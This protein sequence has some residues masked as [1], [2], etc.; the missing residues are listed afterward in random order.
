MFSGNRKTRCWTSIHIAWPAVQGRILGVPGGLKF[1]ETGPKPCPN[2]GV[3]LRWTG[4]GTAINNYLEI[5]FCF[6]FFC[7]SLSRSL[8]LSILDLIS[9]HCVYI[10]QS[11]L[12]WLDI[13]IYIYCILYLMIFNV[14]ILLYINYIHESYRT[15]NTKVIHK[16]A[17]SIYIYVHVCN[18]YDM[19]KLISPKRKPR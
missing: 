6:C 19:M 8:Y 16:C 10:L 1:P 5:C 3:W 7:F 4:K 14:C 2:V 15:C 12:I 11:K 18:M 17:Q 9:I 13:Y